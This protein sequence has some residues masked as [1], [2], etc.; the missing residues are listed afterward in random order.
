VGFVIYRERI[1]KESCI[2]VKRAKISRCKKII[3]AGFYSQLCGSISNPDRFLYKP[4]F[5][6]KG[7]SPMSPSFCKTIK[8]NLPVINELLSEIFSIKL[9]FYFCFFEKD[10]AYGLHPFTSLNVLIKY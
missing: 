7:Q 8:L 9:H 5:K 10:G 6:R 1:G 2:S 4:L 3:E